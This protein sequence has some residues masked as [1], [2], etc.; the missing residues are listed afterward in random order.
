MCEGIHVQDIC[1][2]SAFQNVLNHSKAAFA[3]DHPESLLIVL[4]FTY[5]TVALHL[6]ECGSVTRSVAWYY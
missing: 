5:F 1:N 2:P 3:H 4:I 6:P